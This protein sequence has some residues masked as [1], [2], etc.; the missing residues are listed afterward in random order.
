[1]IPD[2]FHYLAVKKDG[3]DD[4]IL[5]LFTC[6]RSC[7]VVMSNPLCS[8]VLN[9]MSRSSASFVTPS[10]G[11]TRLI[12]LL[13][14]NLIVAAAETTEKNQYFFSPSQKYKIS[15]V[16]LPFPQVAP[17]KLVWEQSQINLFHPSVHLPPCIQGWSWH[18]PA[19]SWQDDR[20][21]PDGNK[22]IVKIIVG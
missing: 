14:S 21:D 17:E 13:P 22:N 16:F 7:T 10:C 5:V 11:N 2:K 12:E 6:D 4:D 18:W 3:S 9:R 1:M 19:M 20:M 8:L 15:R